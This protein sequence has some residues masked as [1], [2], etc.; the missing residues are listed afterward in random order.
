MSTA[1]LID[2][3]YTNDFENILFPG[4][5][6]SDLSDHFPV[7]LNISSDDL[8]VNNINKIRDTRNMKPDHFLKDLENNISRGFGHV[9]FDSNADQLFTHFH[10]IF[11]KTADHH[12]PIRDKTK[13]ERERALK[14]WITRS[15]LKKLILG[16]PSLVKRLK[17]KINVY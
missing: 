2:H 7:F 1:T 5:I 12:A 9:N 11:Y 3:I 6:L 15:I 4:I 10:D 8:K 14:P 17:K 16:I 13:K